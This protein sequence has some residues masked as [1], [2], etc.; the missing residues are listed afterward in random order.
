VKNIVDALNLGPKSGEWL[1]QVGIEDLDSLK[2]KGAINAY[3]A[4]E[5]L[6]IKPSLNL[7]YALEG[8]ITDTHWQT[9]KVRYKT[10]LI[11]ALDAAKMKVSE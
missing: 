3:L 11:L 10:D 7:L 4:V 9:V 1:R 2:Q 8:A 6:G 5:A